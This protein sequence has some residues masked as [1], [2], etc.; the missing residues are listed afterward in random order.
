MKKRRLFNTSEYKAFVRLHEALEGEGFYIHPEMQIGKVLE[1]GEDET[2]SSKE[3]KTFTNAFF[4]FVVYNKKLFPEFVIEFDGPRHQTEVKNRQA[5][6]RKNRLCERAD[7]PLLRIDD[8]LLSEYEKISLLGY[9]VKR[10]IAYRKK[11]DDISLEISERLSHSK[12]VDYDDPWNDPGVVFDLYHPFPVTIEIAKRLYDSYQIVTSY[13]DAEIYHRATSK[14]PHYEFHGLKGSGP[15]GEEHGELYARQIDGTY[16][17][18]KHIQDSLGKYNQEIVH[19]LSMKVNYRWGVPT[20]EETDQK[21]LESLSSV[22]FQGLPGT[23]MSQLAEHFCDFL[24]IRQLEE[25][26]HSNLIY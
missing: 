9:L 11:I 5:D 25:W 26:A 24:A 2:I 17:L 19:E 13:I 23:S 21:H 16:R 7:L 8:S 20:Y 14:Y 12:D 4:D 15:I 10:F 18:E 6:I 22:H 1:L 3:R